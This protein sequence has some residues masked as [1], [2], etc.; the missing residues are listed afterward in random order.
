[1]FVFDL[2]GFIS[3]YFAA[4]VGIVL[5]RFLVLI[6]AP[7]GASRFLP[8]PMSVEVLECWSKFFPDFCPRGLTCFMVVI[9]AIFYI[10]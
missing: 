6:S 7:V 9:G 1:L 2:V 10:C 8:P 5:E 3:S 4:P